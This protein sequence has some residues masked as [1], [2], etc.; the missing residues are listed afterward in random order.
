MRKAR[1]ILIFLIVFAFVGSVSASPFKAPLYGV[2]PISWSYNGNLVLT[3]ISTTTVFSD[4]FGI[5][6]PPPHT[7]LGHVNGISPAVPGTTYNVGRCLKDET[8]AVV[9]FINS[10]TV[11]GNTFYSDVNS[12]ADNHPHANVSHESDGSYTVGFEDILASETTVNPDWDYNDVVL[13]VAC[14]PD[15]ISTPE[16][17]TM[18]LPAALIIGLFGAVLFIKR[19][20]ES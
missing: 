16:F 4:E 3:F 15:P 1:L 10:P 20:K 12:P 18:A 13:N 11:G 14:T 9:L 5:D 6:Q 7:V 19:T 8:V 2:G 17:P